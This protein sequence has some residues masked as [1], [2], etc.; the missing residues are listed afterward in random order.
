[1]LFC[2][3]IAEPVGAGST[4]AVTHHKSVTERVSAPGRKPGAPIKSSLQDGRH[5]AA[6]VFRLD[7]FIAS[8]T[9][10]VVFVT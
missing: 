4:V 1:M 7:D 9:I 8:L 3:A 10:C 5:D 2:K 6:L